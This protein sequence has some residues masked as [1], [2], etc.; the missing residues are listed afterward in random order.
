MKFRFPLWLAALAGFCMS[1]SGCAIEHLSDNTGKALHALT[2]KQTT[3]RLTELDAPQQMS[4]EDADIA[5]KN[6]KQDR[7]KGQLG[8][9]GPRVLN[10]AR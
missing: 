3:V 8:S 2:T 7:K 4:A 1:G 6:K 9:G 5:H 10:L